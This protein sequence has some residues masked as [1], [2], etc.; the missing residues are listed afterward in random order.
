[1]RL[2]TI[3]F[4]HLLDARLPATLFVCPGVHTLLEPGVVPC[5]VGTIYLRRFLLMLM[6][7][8]STP[9][10][11]ATEGLL[12]SLIQQILLLLLMLRPFFAK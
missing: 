11:W 9:A 12:W 8:L 3:E 7:M 5:L 6:L 2:D 10:G 4:H 1:M